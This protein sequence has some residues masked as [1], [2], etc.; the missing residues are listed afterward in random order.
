M[1]IWPQVSVQ[2][3]YS[4]SYV[5]Q[6]DDLRRS[7]LYIWIKYCLITNKS[8]SRITEYFWTHNRSKGKPHS[9]D[10]SQ[11]FSI[12]YF[13]EEKRSSINFTLDRR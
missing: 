10:S 11:L 3:P 9:Y 5:V 7:C 6:Y 12:P 1:N 4:I 8:F 2:G 13:A